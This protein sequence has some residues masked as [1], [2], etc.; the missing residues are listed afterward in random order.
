MPSVR[1]AV[2]AL[3]VE[4]DRSLLR[5]I[6]DFLEREGFRVTTEVD[7]RWALRTFEVRPIDLVVLD[8]NLPGLDGFQLSEKIQSFP[9][10]RPAKVVVLSDRRHSHPQ[11][12]AARHGAT[13][14]LR[15]PVSLDELREVLRT[16][17][18]DRYPVPV[19]T[20]AI[21]MYDRTD[22]D[23]EPRLNPP[24]TATPASALRIRPP[25]ASG[26]K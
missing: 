9:K 4:N 3:V 19:A 21:G 10:S 20:A 23:I 18:G 24:R 2:S 17:L 15:K 13:A 14:L 5:S 8:V 12:E 26:K 7:G 22:G 25:A 6:V 16:A 1:H 11:R